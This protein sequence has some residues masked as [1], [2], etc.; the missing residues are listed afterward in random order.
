MTAFLI[1]LEKDAQKMIEVMHIS[2]KEGC[3]KDLELATKEFEDN[4]N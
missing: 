4:S 3:A 1:L 2:N